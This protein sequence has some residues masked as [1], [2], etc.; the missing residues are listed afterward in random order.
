MVA[1][2]SNKYKQ[3]KSK[4]EIK[5]QSPQRCKDSNNVFMILPQDYYRQVFNETSYTGIHTRLL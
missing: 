5:E 2:L 1:V 4:K 3:K